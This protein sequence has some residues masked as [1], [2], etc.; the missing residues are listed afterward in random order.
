MTR[1]WH[2]RWAPPLLTGLALGLSATSG[3][4]A[5]ERAAAWSQYRDRGAAVQFDLPAQLF[6]PE[7]AGQEEGSG[8][9]FSTS[10][11]RARLRVFRR[12]N[13]ARE[14]PRAYLRRVAKTEN[15]NFTYIR[16]TD[17]FFVA[18]GTRDGAIFYRRCN[19]SSSRIGC[20]HL[21]YPQS[22]K[23]AW[24]A[25]VTRISRSMRLLDAD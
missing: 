20:L 2:A 17:R 13:T 12:A 7:S 22:E 19:F 16:T 24:D 3:A 18:S 21:D 25:T 1:R 23:R 5:L 8:T 10:D 14:S 15:A 11:G 6:R 4:P 9:T